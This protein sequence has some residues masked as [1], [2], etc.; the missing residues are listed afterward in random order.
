MFGGLTSV[1]GWKEGREME[2]E[3]RWVPFVVDDDDDT[4]VLLDVEA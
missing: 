3:E 2:Y 1:G 4:A